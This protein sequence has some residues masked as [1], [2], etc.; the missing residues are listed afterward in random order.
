M[1]MLFSFAMG[2]RGSV[3]HLSGN[4]DYFQERC[5]PMLISRD[6]SSL[7]VDRLSDQAKR[8]NIAVTCFYF[9]F[10]ARKEQSATSILGSLLKQIVSGMERILEGMLRAFKNQK[11][12]IGGCGPQLVD[13]VK[14]L[15]A[16]TSSQPTFICIDALD[17]CVGVQRRRVLDSLNQ[18][19]EKSPRTRIFVTGR[20]HILAEIEKGLARKVA[21]LSVSPRKGDI[22]TYLLA[23]L[24]EDETPDAMDESLEANI[25]EKIAENISE[26][27]VG[28]TILR[29]L[30]HT[31]R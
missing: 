16:L 8:Q 28:A 22:I 29:I 7:V 11:E 19:L 4:K 15:Q 14:L 25:L 10:A 9:D 3:K 17:E 2:I 30:L 13:I 5:E 26:T 20:P 31:I 6:T 23:R 12:A 1:I 21:C 18:I 24:S 27:C